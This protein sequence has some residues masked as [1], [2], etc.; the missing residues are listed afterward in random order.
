MEKSE[1]RKNRFL[2]GKRK[3]YGIYMVYSCGACIGY[4]RLG[5]N[6]DKT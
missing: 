5:G 2:E 6:D 3:A 4:S 1:F